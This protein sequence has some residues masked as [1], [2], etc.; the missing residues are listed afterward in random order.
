ISIP[1]R[2]PSYGFRELAFPVDRDLEDAMQV[3]QWEKHFAPVRRDNEANLCPDF[4]QRFLRGH[5]Q[6]ARDLVLERCFR[7]FCLPLASLE[8][9]SE[10]TV[11]FRQALIRTP[12]GA[13]NSKQYDY[14]QSSENPF[15]RQ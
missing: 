11:F 5:F 13:D 1:A 14:D 15:E 2:K 10:F 3:E 8:I 7:F 4:T 9:R 6:E 12:S